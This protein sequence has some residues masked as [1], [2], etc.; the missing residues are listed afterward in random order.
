[1]GETTDI[2]DE[3]GIVIVR[4]GDIRDREIDIVVGEEPIRPKPVEVFFGDV[5]EGVEEVPGDGVFAV[6]A[7]HKPVQTFSKQRVAQHVLDGQVGQGRFTVGIVAIADAFQ[8]IRG[9]DDGQV[10]FGRGIV[11]IA[12]DAKLLIEL[13][14]PFFAEIGL[15][16]KVFE[17]GSPAFVHKRVAGFVDAHI[18]RE[19]AVGDLVFG[20]ETGE[21]GIGGSIVVYHHGVF[22]VGI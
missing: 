10:F 13:V 12:V 7:V 19:P 14:V 3:N 5:V 20:D 9:R 1:D 4:A 18:E 2:V 6:P 8:G 11:R 15:P 16:D 21:E 22:H 17:G